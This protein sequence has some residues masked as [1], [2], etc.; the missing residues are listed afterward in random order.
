MVMSYH[1]KYIFHIYNIRKFCTHH[2]TSS[3]IRLENTNLKVIHCII[4]F[5]A[6][7]S[8]IKSK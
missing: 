7:N 8:G 1:P 5:D 6:T 2:I 3:S 4:F